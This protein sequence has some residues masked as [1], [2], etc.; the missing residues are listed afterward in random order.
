MSLIALVLLVC[1]VFLVLAAEW[2]RLASRVDVEVF[3]RRRRDRRKARFRVIEGMRERPKDPA[4]APET[5]IDDFA[6]SVQRDL[7]QLPTTDDR[8]R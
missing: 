4:P 7:E 2:P 3:E 1:A 8:D 5:D 6:A